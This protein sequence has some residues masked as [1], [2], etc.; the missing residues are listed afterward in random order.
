MKNKTK[1]TNSYLYE[2]RNQNQIFIDLDR[3]RSFQCKKAKLV[4]L[5][6]ISKGYEVFSNLP[7]EKCKLSLLPKGI[8][9]ILGCSA[10]F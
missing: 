4:L 3:Q 1:Q 5:Y 2:G 9:K 8:K 7:P 10:K 6:W